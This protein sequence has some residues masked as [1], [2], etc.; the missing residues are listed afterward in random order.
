MLLC[1]LYY[2]ILYYIILYYIILYYIILYY[3]IHSITQRTEF[4]NRVIPSATHIVNPPSPG[5]N[6][7]MVVH[8]NYY[9]ND[10]SALD[11]VRCE[12]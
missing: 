4:R 8:S 2:I 9:I 1:L 3:I 11:V 5:Q 12:C 6:Y 7:K 10:C